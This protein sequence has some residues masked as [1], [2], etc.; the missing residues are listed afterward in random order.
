MRKKRAEPQILQDPLS[1]DQSR[2]LLATAGVIRDPV[3][4]DV[5][6]TALER[7]IIDTDVLQRLKRIRQLA[8]VDFVYPGATHTRFLH[9]LGV[10]YVCNNMLLACNNTARN[11]ERLAANGEARAVRIPHYPRLLARLVA[12]LHDAAHVPFGHVFERE[13]HVFRKGTDEWHDPWRWEKVFGLNSELRG[14][15]RR[16]LRK[17]LTDSTGSGSFPNGCTAEQ[18]GDA[19]LDEVG[20]VLRAK[21]DDEKDDE[22]DEEKDDG[23]DKQTAAQRDVLYLRYPFVYDIVS[24]TLCADLVD[25]LKRDMF[26]CGLPGDIGSRCLQYLGVV[27]V[28]ST[29]TGNSNGPWTVM[30]D[31]E[32]Y[33]FPRREVGEDTS[34]CRLALL[35]YRYNERGGAACKPYVVVEAV[36]LVRRRKMLGEAAYF[37]KTK[38]CATSMLA[39]A[40]AVPDAGVHRGEDVWAMSDDDVLG[41]LAATDRDLSSDDLI[42][43][44]KRGAIRVGTLAR[45]LRARHLF[46]PIFRLEYHADTGDPVGRTLWQEVYPYFRKPENRAEL[47]DLLERIIHAA[48]HSDTEFDPRRAF[49]SVSISCPD[50]RMQLKGLGMYVLE[51]PSDEELQT[52]EAAAK[53]EWLKNEIRAIQ[54]GHHDLWRLEVYVYCFIASETFRVIE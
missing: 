28:R 8:M 39:A 50:K 37:H 26:F 51:D 24:N 40:A 13:A 48:H 44:G 27:P 52:L 4:G 6:I 10:L 29:R 18:A 32:E 41:K 12:L 25:Y 42:D 20:S 47:I 14:V 45:K 7:A 19:L 21:K 34:L 17:Y 9:S 38:L 2:S 31:A 11:C 30:K 1:D 3:H 35:P 16:F 46:K 53:K 23:K 43:A 54:T 33:A 5:H 36:D 15:V 49:G 22:K